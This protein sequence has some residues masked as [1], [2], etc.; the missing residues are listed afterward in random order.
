MGPRKQGLGQ[1]S[2]ALQRQHLVTERL[3]QHLRG[4]SHQLLISR[5]QH[6]RFS[7]SQGQINTVVHRVIPMTRKSE[8]FQLKVT[9]GFDV[10][11]ERSSPAEAQLQAFGL[12]LTSTL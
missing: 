10:I 2:Q 9:V 6:G 5:E 4:Q 12:Q 8:C 11:H 3:R 1:G 7:A